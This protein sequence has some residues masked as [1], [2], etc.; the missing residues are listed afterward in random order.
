[1]AFVENR[2]IFGILRI[3]CGMGGMGCG[4]GCGRWECQTGQC[5]ECE[6]FAMRRGIANG[7]Q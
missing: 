3:T 2:V 4:C 6:I 7:V 1:M 5:G